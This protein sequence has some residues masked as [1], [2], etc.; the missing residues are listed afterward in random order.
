MLNICFYFQVHQP[1]R[2]K[3]Y[4][5]FNVGHDHDYFNDDGQSDLNNKKVLRKV[6]E[7]S[8]LPTNA[9]LLHL[10]QKHPEFKVSFSFSG[11]VL[12]QFE[13]NAPDVLESFKKLVRTGRVEIL[14]ETYYHSLAFL[15][16][17]KEFRRQIEMHRK[18]IEEL[19][20]QTPKVFRN[21]E[22][23][24]RNDIGK[25]ISNLGYKGM[26][27]EGADHILGWR[28]PNFLY[29]AKDVP[30]VLLLKN[31]KLSDDIAFRFG[32]RSWKEYPLTAPKFS[33]WLTSHHGSGEIVNLFMDYETFG[34]HQWEDTGIF[35]FMRHLPGELL[36]HPDNRF[37]TPSEAVR[38]LTPVSEIDMPN[39]VSWADIERDLSAW[40]SNPIQ[41]DALRSIYALEDK[42]LETGNTRLIEDWRKL[43]T[44]DH[45]YYMCTKWFSDG[46][47]HAYF[48]PYESPYE[49]F[50]SYMNVLQDLNNRIDLIPPPNIWFRVK[51]GLQKLL[52]Y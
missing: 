43:Q 4:R 29:K 2:V 39:Y 15:H 37:V 8:Y 45:F 41:H 23:I 13:K 6:S 40:R 21:T 5:I 51:K 16:S 25:E 49:A 18:K 19:F 11:V 24:Y 50:M 30:L 35:E 27:A 46:D 1:H 32:S 14:S 17:P 36:K 12:E 52:A 34:E 22:L 3:R 47:V 48:N 28:S 9:L 33:Q 20:G 7:K 42:V 26:L 44:S 31:Y 38:T 10:L